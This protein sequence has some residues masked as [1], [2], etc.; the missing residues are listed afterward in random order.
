MAETSMEGPLSDFIKKLMFIHQFNISKGDVSMLGVHDILL[1][2]EI[3]Q[4]INTPNKDLYKKLKATFKRTFDV[5]LMKIGSSTLEQKYQNMMDIL[6]TM[7]IGDVEQ[8]FINSAQHQAIMKV[9]KSPLIELAIQNGE[10]NKGPYCNV[11]KAILAGAFS[12]LFNR[13]IDCTETKCSIT[14]TEYCQF[15]IKEN[16][17]V[18]A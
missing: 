4:L 7:G 18:V 1:P 14:G 9:Y 5:F 15:A 3:L 8:E 10:K 12:S 13:D 11:T 2:A 16:R 6:N 17:G